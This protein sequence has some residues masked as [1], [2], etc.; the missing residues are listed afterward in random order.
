MK[1]L[2][3]YEDLSDKKLESESIKKLEREIELKT[4]EVKS[5]KRELLKLENEFTKIKNKPLKEFFAICNSIFEKYKV[6]FSFDGDIY[7][8]VMITLPEKLRKVEF[9]EYE[10][11]KNLQVQNF[12]IVEGDEC[13]IVYNENL[14]ECLYIDS[15]IIMNNLE[16]FIELE[17]Y[18]KSNKFIPYLEA[19]KMGLM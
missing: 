4:K 6:K 7:E 18:L 15:E 10:N 19:G 17:K 14:N 12:E 2:K 16:Y 5:K 8:H 13:Y 11:N 9:K 1:Y 3:T